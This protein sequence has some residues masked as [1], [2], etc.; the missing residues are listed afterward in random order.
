[1]LAA[2]GISAERMWI[3]NNIIILSFSG[4]TFFFSEADHSINEG[5]LPAPPTII[6]PL[7]KNPDTR[8]A[9][10]VIFQVCPVTIEEANATGCP[11]PPGA[12][13][14]HDPKSPF[15][16]SKS[17]LHFLLCVCQSYYSNYEPLVSNTQCIYE[18]SYT[19]VDIILLIRQSLLDFYGGSSPQSLHGFSAY[20]RY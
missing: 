15:K 19:Y 2:S 3:I 14:E 12:Q 17:K 20:A 9:N 1:M 16:A 18:S 11:I 10:P 4:V 13:L 7:S 6:A 5:S 8:L